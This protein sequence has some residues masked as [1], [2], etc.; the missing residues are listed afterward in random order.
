ME[1]FGVSCS[2]W[3]AGLCEISALEGK[4]ADGLR[5]RLGVVPCYIPPRRR[6]TAATATLDENSPSD[7][8]APARSHYQDAITLTT[9]GF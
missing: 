8:K 2:V 4:K 3:L 1:G 6:L 5:Q 9:L 7:V